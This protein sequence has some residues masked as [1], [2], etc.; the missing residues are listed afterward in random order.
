VQKTLVLSNEQNKLS[1]LPLNNL[2]MM[3]HQQNIPA[4]TDKKADKKNKG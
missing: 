2:I 3:E 4:K 1:A